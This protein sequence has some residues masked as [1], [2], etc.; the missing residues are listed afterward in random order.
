MFGKMTRAVATVA[1]GA[2][3]LGLKLAVQ[4]LLLKKLGRSQATIAVRGLDHPVYFRPRTSD[5]FELT[6]L[7]GAKRVAIDLSLN[8][9]FIVDAGANAGYSALRFQSQF[10]GARIV[11]IEP[12]GGN[13]AIL[14]KNCAP[15]PNIAI[16]AAALWPT[17]SRLAIRSPE[18]G[19]NAFQVDERP[20]GLVRAISV[21]DIMTKYSLPHIDLLKI[22]IEGSERV[23]FSHPKTAAWLPHVRMMLIELHDDFETGCTEAVETATKELFVRRGI[24]DEYVFYVSTHCVRV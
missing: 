1:R 7:L 16:E 8:P 9:R 2:P 20:D 21:Q 13:V 10:P 6:R 17:T 19:L 3:Q 23:L 11:A 18:V 24:I 5:I 15:Y 4:D 12:E 22:D 14:T